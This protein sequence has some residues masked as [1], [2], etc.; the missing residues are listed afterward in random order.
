M[1][2]IWN[3][4]SIRCAFFFL[5]CKIID[6]Y[7]CTMSQKGRV[8]SMEKDSLLGESDFYLRTAGGCVSKHMGRRNNFFAWFPEKQY[9]LF[10]FIYS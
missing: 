4:L 1:T 8:T 7:L 9:P 5:L 3:S 2:F 6:F 10:I